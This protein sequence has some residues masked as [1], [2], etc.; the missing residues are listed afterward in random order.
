ML[1][2]TALSERAISVRQPWAWAIVHAGKDVENRSEAA[3]RFFRPAI[4][5][6][7]HIHAGKK[8]ADDDYA[9][10][11]EYM[12]KLGVTPPVREQLAFGSITIC[13][14]ASPAS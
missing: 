4:G 14:R 12:A 9:F 2:Q 6:R 5:K 13:G 7:V 10:A 1:D 3:M 11:V 8:M